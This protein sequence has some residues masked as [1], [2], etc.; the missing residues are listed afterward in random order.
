[1]ATPKKSVYE[2]LNEIPFKDKVE[3]KGKIKY[4]SWAYA[5]DAL[6]KVYPTAQRTVYEDPSTGWNYFTDGRTGWVKVGVTVDGLEHIDYLPVMDHRNS[7]IPIDK[8]TQFDVNKTIQRS[9]AKAIAMHGLGIQL[10]TGEDLPEDPGARTPKKETPKQGE[11]KISLQ[12]EDENWE[13]VLTYVAKSY[14]AGIETI[15]QQLS[16][17]YSISTEVGEEIAKF[18]E[19]CKTKTKEE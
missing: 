2:S 3:T 11:S 15:L 14:M 6:K 17:K 13:R 5:W 1:M 9:T 10:W 18:I 4:L 19:F 12:V 7:A 8:I 16:R